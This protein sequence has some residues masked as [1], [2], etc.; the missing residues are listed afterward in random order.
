MFLMKQAE[1]QQIY[2]DGSVILHTRSLK[3]G[4]LGKGVL[5]TVPAVLIKVIQF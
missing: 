4:K 2:S 5:V 1:V 3:Y